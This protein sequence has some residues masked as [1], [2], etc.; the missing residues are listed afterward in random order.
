MTTHNTPQTERETWWL[1]HFL[2]PQ[3]A[4]VIIPATSGGVSSTCGGGHPDPLTPRPDH[5]IL[6]QTT[7]YLST[8]ASRTSRSMYRSSVPHKH[9][10]VGCDRPWP[11]LSAQPSFLYLLMTIL[12]SGHVLAACPSRRPA[13]PVR[14]YSDPSC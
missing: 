2:T 7:S 9:P 14:P 6:S 4:C 3:R 11:I 10:T 1:H 13:H 12:L 5:S 8:A